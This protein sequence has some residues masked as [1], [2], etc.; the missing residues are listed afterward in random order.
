L[1][2]VIFQTLLLKCE[3]MAGRLEQWWNCNDKGKTTNWEKYLSHN[4]LV[5]HRSQ[6]AWDR[7]RVFFVRCC[8]L[9]SCP[10][11]LKLGNYDVG[12]IPYWCLHQFFPFWCYRRLGPRLI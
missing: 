8:R 5:Y 11:G 3:F 6:I 1:T 2:G 9:I 10:W 4:H 7:T 12:N